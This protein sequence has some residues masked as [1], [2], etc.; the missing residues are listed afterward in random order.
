MRRQVFAGIIT[1]LAF[2]SAVGQDYWSTVPA[3]TQAMT[4]RSQHGT[5][6]L[7]NY[8]WFYPYLKPTPGCTLRVQNCIIDTDGQ[9]GELSES[10][11]IQAKSGWRLYGGAWNQ[12]IVEDAIGIAWVVT[13]DAIDPA[14]DF[15]YNPYQVGK[16]F[17]FY[18]GWG[19]SY[20]PNDV[21]PY[22]SH[23]PEMQELTEDAWRHY[24]LDKFPRNGRNTAKAPAP[25]A[26]VSNIRNVPFEVAYCRVT[27]SGETALSPSHQFTPAAPSPGQSVA[28]VV[29]VQYA[30]GAFH[31]QG[32]IG[33]HV[34]I[35]YADGSRAA[36]QRVP[37]PSCTGTPANPDQWLWP[38]W[39]RQLH[40]VRTVPGAPT[41][42]PAPTPQSRLSDLHRFLRG[43]PVK[44]AEVLQRFGLPTTG[45]YVGDVVVPNASQYRV[46]CPVIDEWGNGDSGTTG[47]P[48]DQKFGRRIRTANFGGWRIEAQPSQ[49][50]H[51]SWPTLLIHNSY[52]RWKGVTIISNG[53][54]ALAFSD[55]SGGQCFGNQFDEV[56]CQANTVAGR[57]TCGIR[58]DGACQAAGHTASELLFRDCGSNG[59]IANWIAGNQTANLRFDRLHAN[60]YSQDSRGSVFFVHGVPSALKFTGGL[61]CDAYLTNQPQ[62]GQRGV[63]FRTAMYASRLQVDDIWVDA[64]F[65][66]FIECNAIDGCQVKM[67]GGK[68]NIRGIKPVLGLFA[69]S[70]RNVSTWKLEDIETQP[71][72]GTNMPRIITGSYRQFRPLFD[73]TELEKCTVREPSEATTLARM[74]L[75]YGPGATVQARDELGYKVPSGGG[76]VITNSLT[77]GAQLPREDYPIIM[78]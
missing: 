42:T 57:V 33:Y 49:G 12:P 21:S 43:D 39:Q 10:T 9:F 63:I 23:H 25:P 5:T 4:Y 55:Y 59:S 8:T 3:P 67:I 40:I 53:G 31:P 32:T 20:L 46:Y 24:S 1:L 15:Q 29:S 69:V 75:F 56:V 34:Y 30:I 38:I 64:G 73:R 45:V 50:G 52:S 51:T 27:E 26:Y 65:V 72:P 76:Y 18:T 48:P 78:P 54:D 22:S 70:Q 7:S 68:L 37:A 28:N 44:D 61:Y 58:I 6:H 66:R 19:G 11:V 35:R 17:Y 77:A 41:H 47:A 2:V 14:D 71:D 16:S 74:K 62:T 60:S 13:I 36:W